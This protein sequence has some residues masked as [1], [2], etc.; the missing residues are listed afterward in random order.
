MGPPSVPGRLDSELVM[1][2]NPLSRQV[3]PSAPGLTPS[4][5]RSAVI[6]HSP[7][8][9]PHS[10]VYLSTIQKRHHLP[11]ALWSMV[12]FQRDPEFSIPSSQH[13]SVIA[14]AFSTLSW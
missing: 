6:Q 1:N 13:S 12:K 14:R 3:A 8:H 5:L 10:R 4:H 9:A 2:F 7:S 11:S